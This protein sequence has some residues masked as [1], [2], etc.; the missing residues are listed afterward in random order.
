MQVVGGDC[1]AS[2]GR[3]TFTRN[4]TRM[5]GSPSTLTSFGN[6]EFD[7]NGTDIFGAYTAKGTL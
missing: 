4:V 2:V 1:V 6:N 7:R 5:S 3:T